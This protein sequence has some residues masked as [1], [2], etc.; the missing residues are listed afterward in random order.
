[1][2]YYTYKISESINNYCFYI[3]SYIE[4]PE[5]ALLH[6]EN[7]CAHTDNK[8]TGYMNY[9]GWDDI[10]IE[11]VDIPPMDVINNKI[12]PTPNCMNITDDYQSLI[13]VPEKLSKKKEPKPK[14]AKEPKPRAKKVNKAVVIK[15]NGEVTMDN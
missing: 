7:Y 11:K 8:V 10:Q 12:P 1:M 13:V 9:C 15:Q 4:V 6:F 2:N 5:M 3:V 14:P